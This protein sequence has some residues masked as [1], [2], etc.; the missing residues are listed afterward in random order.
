[1]QILWD[2]GFHLPFDS[3][4]EE[5]HQ[6]SSS[7]DSCENSS[8]AKE[9]NS[10]K[11][12]NKKEEKERRRKLIQRVEHYKR[13]QTLSKRIIKRDLRKTFSRMYVNAVNSGD[14]T[15][16]QAFTTRY[17]TTDCQFL[18][19]PLSNFVPQGINYTS[20]EEH[21]KHVQAVYAVFPDCV[22]QP[23]GC[24]IVR[25]LYQ[26]E[27]SIVELFVNAKATGLV[28][29]D[30]QQSEVVVGGGCD[31]DGSHYNERAKRCFPP[32]V[33]FVDI[34][35]KISFYMNQNGYIVKDIV[36]PVTSIPSLISI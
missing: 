8:C 32:N 7:G 30:E 33:V 13:L 14:L 26:E 18:Y 25:Q 24:R 22:L 34:M 36:S 17:M 29:P 28:Y 35:V 20:P 11:N 2:L 31:G 4:D 9:K 16:F 5:N 6:L 12:R 19:Q 15:V 3:A 1:M 27:F 10:E 23:M 21:V